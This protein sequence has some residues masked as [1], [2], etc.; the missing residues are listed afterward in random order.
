MIG[1]KKLGEVKSV[2]FEINKNLRRGRT[3]ILSRAR[4][5]QRRGCTFLS[6]VPGLRHKCMDAFSL[7]FSAAEGQLSFQYPQGPRMSLDTLKLGSL[8]ETSIPHDL[9]ASSRKCDPSEEGGEG[10]PLCSPARAQ[11]EV[12]DLSCELHQFHTLEKI[13]V[14]L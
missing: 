3:P 1:T 5:G 6:C 2:M 12:A 10:W 4:L 9:Q 14:Q 11:P 13:P 7:G 8:E